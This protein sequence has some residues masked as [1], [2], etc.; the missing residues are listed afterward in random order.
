MHSTKFTAYLRLPFAR[1]GR[2]GLPI[3]CLGLFGLFLIVTVFGLF[4]IV[5]FVTLE[6]G[7]L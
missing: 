4:L 1:E 7:R 2:E 3:E 6:G 5:A